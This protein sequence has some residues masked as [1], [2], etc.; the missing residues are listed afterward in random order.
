MVRRRIG[1]RW[2]HPRCLAGR[3]GGHRGHGG[4][5]AGGARLRG[6]G[7]GAGSRSLRRR[8]RGGA[9]AG[10]PPAGQRA[11]ARPVPR[12]GL[13]SRFRLA[14]R[15]R[16]GHLH[17]HGRRLRDGGPGRVDRPTPGRPGN[18]GG[19]R[20][21]PWAGRAADLPPDHPRAAARLPPPVRRTGV[22]RRAGGHRTRGAHRGRAA[23]RPPHPVGSA[24]RPGHHLRR[25]GASARPGSTGRRLSRARPGQAPGAGRSGPDHR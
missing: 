25:G 11:V 16:R 9:T 14:D 22:D 19:V 17:H 1:E 12:L 20:S 2:S 13:R 7:G 5:R 23:R 4:A 8:H 21:G 6:A 3:A 24:H 18:R 15:N 10:P